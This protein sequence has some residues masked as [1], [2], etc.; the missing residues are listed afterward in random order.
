MKRLAVTGGTGFIGGHLITALRER[1]DHVTALTRD[2]ERA[3]ARL[4]PP[5]ELLKWDGRDERVSLGGADVVV[6]LAGEQ[7]VGRRWTPGLKAAIF[8]SRVLGA[9]AIVS[10]IERAEPRPKVLLCA[11]G[12]GYYGA[13]GDEPVDEKTTEPGTDFLAQVCVAWERAAMRAEGLGCRV[14]RLRFG[15]VLGRGG[16]ALTEM[17]MPFRMYVGGPLGTGKQVFSWIHLRDAVHAILL[18]IDDETISGPVNVTSP[19][20]VTNEELARA[21]GKALHRPSFVRAPAFALRARFGEGADPIL[22]G[23]RAA[24]SVLE[25]HGFQ[26]AHPTVSDALED[27]LGPE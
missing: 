19:S 16:G 18:C 13:R 20:A 22:T 6:H 21:M 11:S 14:V 12:V 9:E 27:A 25:A 7:A 24:P 10:A 5:V 2:P 17:A 1:G 4:P 8:E 15:V 23:Q 26:W 3:R